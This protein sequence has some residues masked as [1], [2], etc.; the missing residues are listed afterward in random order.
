MKIS[1]DAAAGGALMAKPM[2]EA[3]QL[4]EDMA[5]NKYHWA[6]ERATLRKEGDMILMLSLCL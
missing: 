2:N 5:S 6:S 4:L 3:K 1:I